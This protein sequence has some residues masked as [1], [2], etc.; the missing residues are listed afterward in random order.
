MDRGAC[1]KNSKF[2]QAADKAENHMAE[3]SDEMTGTVREAE[4]E[5]VRRHREGDKSGWRH[6]PGEVGNCVSWVDMVNVEK[7]PTCCTMLGK[8]YA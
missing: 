2:Q 1:N 3:K 4:K 8:F 5:K 6:L 7:L